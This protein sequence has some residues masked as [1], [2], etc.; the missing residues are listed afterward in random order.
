M[1]R[2]PLM[3][4]VLLALLALAGCAADVEPSAAPTRAASVAPMAVVTPSPTPVPVE[5]LYDIVVHP[6]PCRSNGYSVYTNKESGGIN[7]RDEV[8][9]LPHEWVQRDGRTVC[10]NCGVEKNDQN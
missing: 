5:L 9:R 6:P 4:A 1:M 7:I 10:R 2:K 8:P 3:G